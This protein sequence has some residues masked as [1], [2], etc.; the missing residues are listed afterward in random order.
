MREYYRLWRRSWAQRIVKSVPHAIPGLCGMLTHTNLCR[1][2]R[3]CSR[4]LLSLLMLWQLLASV[5][6]HPLPVAT[7]AHA[8][9]DQ[10]SHAAVMP[11]DCPHEHMQMSDGERAADIQNDHHAGAADGAH[12][13]GNSCHSACKCP[14]AGTPALAFIA[15]DVPG[16]VPE[17]PVSAPEFQSL[18]FAPVASLLRP[19]IA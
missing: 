16:T 6:A 3:A 10:T 7:A 8:E 15:S 14:C 5:V 11:A 18:L 2:S 19:P 9:I 17:H 12:H 1:M 4:S 13:T